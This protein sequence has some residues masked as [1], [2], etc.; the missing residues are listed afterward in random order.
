[1][2]VGPVRAILDRSEVPYEYID[3]ARNPQAAGQVKQ[4]NNGY[5]SVPTIVFQD[6]ST[7]TEPTIG[8]LRTRLQDLG[9][10][11]P[12][13]TFLDKARVAINN[14]FTYFFAVVLIVFGLAGGNTPI[15]ILG[16]ILL[17]LGL[18]LELRHRRR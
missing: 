15:V 1:M 9:Y 2:M 14:P 5:A 11:V 3:I 4:I 13:L 17:I 10:Q 12:S 6:E 7:L 8:E 18:L 16:T